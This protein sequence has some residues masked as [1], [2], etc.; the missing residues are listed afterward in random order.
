[1]AAIRHLENSVTK[2]VCWYQPEQF[3]NGTVHP[4][5]MHIIQSFVSYIVKLVK[6]SALW[7][8]ERYLQWVVLS[9][10]LAGLSECISTAFEDIFVTWTKEI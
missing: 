3:H 10:D 4:G 2:Q 5:G 1:M 9:K 6:G 7:R 8:V